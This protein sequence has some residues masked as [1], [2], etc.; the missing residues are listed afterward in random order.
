MF[1]QGDICDF[2][3]PV[4]FRHKARC[5]GN[6]HSIVKRRNAV[7]G[8]HRDAQRVGL[9]AS[10]A[11]LHLL[12]RGKAIRCEL[13]LALNTIRPTETANITLKEH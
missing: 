5:A 1:L 7:A 3:V 6:G 13:H 2:S 10:M 4:V 8:H 9:T 11:A 12:R